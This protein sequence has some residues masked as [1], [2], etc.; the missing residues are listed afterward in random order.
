MG[1]H[2][3]VICT[4][5]TCTHEARV[6]PRALIERGYGDI[7]LNAIERRLICSRCG[8]VKPAVYREVW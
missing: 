1:G 5:A 6:M 4:S 8:A 2:L 7:S 3:K